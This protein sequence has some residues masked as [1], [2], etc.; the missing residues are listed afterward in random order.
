MLR[1]HLRREGNINKIMDEEYRGRLNGYNRL[2]AE[3]AAVTRDLLATKEQLATY[4][5]QELKVSRW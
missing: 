3:S 4:E 2:M 1:Y 5:K